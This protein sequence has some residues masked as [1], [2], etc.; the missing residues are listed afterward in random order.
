LP[1][2]LQR[3]RD[4]AGEAEVKKWVHEAIQDDTQLVLF[5][6]QFLQNEYTQPLPDGTAISHY[7]LDPQWFEPFIEP[8]DIAKRLENI[9]KVDEF[10]S[11]QQIAI[12]EFL[13]EYGFRQQGKD[14]DDV[15]YRTDVAC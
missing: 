14:P 11:E 10:A 6:E 15:R 3:Y 12:K 4:W 5:I 7:R 1:A 8:S 9:D 2:L 13:Q